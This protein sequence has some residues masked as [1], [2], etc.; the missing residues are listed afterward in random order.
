VT[1]LGGGART[2]GASEGV[3]MVTMAI[4]EGGTRPRLIKY[5]RTR[6]EGRS[7]LK[8]ALIDGR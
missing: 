8:V 3:E 2:S 6:G 7:L 1:T 4:L 5:S